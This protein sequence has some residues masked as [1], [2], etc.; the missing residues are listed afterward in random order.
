MDDLTEVRMDH[1]GETSS[2]TEAEDDERLEEGSLSSLAHEKLR[3]EV[4]SGRLRP[5]E[6]LVELE[7]SER[8]GMSRT[9][10]RDA[11]AQLAAD[12]LVDRSKR[13]WTVHEYT[14]DELREIY[15]GRS[16]LEGYAAFLSAQRATSAE[17]NLIEETLERESSMLDPLGTDTNVNLNIEFH[18]VVIRSCGNA[19]L[20]K[21]V[22]RNAEF[23][24]NFRIASLYTIDEYK[25]S[26]DGHYR[27]LNALRTHDGETA[28]RAMREHLVESLNVLLSKGRW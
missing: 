20:I 18:S 24:F 17:L 7:L 9:P 12:G 26:L 16:A 3:N 19:R 13:S 15:E 2:R 28:E 25:S 6:R 11:L 27:L 1:L 10:V 8:L 22:E 23:Y 4:I 21:M 14:R 5:N